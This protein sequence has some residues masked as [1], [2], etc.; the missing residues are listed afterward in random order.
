MP[1]E[2][3]AHKLLVIL[4]DRSQTRELD[5]CPQDTMDTSIPMTLR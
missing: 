4:G 1:P 3:L 5:S 2:R